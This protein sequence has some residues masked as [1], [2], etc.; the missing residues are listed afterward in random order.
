MRNHQGS[1]G[2][3]SID[4]FFSFRCMQAFSRCCKQVGSSSCGA[5]TSHCSGFSSETQALGM[6]TQLQLQ[7]SRTWAQWLWHM[8]L[9]VAWYVGPYRWNQGWN[10]CPLHYKA[11][12]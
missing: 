11:N 9:V 3:E 10:R 7:G 6:W 5:Q 2:R 4:D 8:G 12:S 1:C